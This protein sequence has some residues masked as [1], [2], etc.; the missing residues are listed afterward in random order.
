MAGSSR[1]GDL[2]WLSTDLLRSARAPIVY[3]NVFLGENA[4]VRVQLARTDNR[5]SIDEASMLHTLG[6]SGI[7]AGP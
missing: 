7:V 5:R 4:T 3:E 2:P 6:V 1:V